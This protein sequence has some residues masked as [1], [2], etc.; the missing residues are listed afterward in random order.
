MI[1]KPVLIH[2]QGDGMITVEVS[3][4]IS[5]YRSQYVIIRIQMN[6]YI[7]YIRTQRDH[8]YLE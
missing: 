4:Y 2:T 7:R 3:Q 5:Q 1:M 6:V 8:I